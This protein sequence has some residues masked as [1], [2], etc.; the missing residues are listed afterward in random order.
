MILKKYFKDSLLFNSKN[1]LYLNI[2]YFF[3]TLLGLVCVLQ[4]IYLKDF[5]F[6]GIFTQF[7]TC[8]VILGH[9]FAFGIGD[10]ILRNIPIS[11][12]NNQSNDKFL[13]A[14]ALTVLIGFILFFF[15]FFDLYFLQKLFR[16]ILL[17]F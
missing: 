16:E 8:F 12:N 9:L 1:Y 15:F 2:S 17:Y 3:Q 11:K 14:L 5:D 10:S 13:S 6:L 4:I 7:Y